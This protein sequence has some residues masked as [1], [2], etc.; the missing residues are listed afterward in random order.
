MSASWEM[1]LPLGQGGAGVW[2]RTAASPQAAPSFQT[3]G[4]GGGM[5]AAV[6]WSGTGP[7]ADTRVQEKRNVEAGLG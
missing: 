5:K 6:T 7:G 1:Q 2:A 4:D 3:P